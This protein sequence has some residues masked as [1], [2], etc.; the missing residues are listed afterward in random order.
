MSILAA[1]GVVSRKRRVGTIFHQMRLRADAPHVFVVGV[2]ISS[3]T[4]TGYS[5]TLNTFIRYHLRQAGCEDR[6]YVLRD[7][8][9]SSARHE[10]RKID[11]YPWLPQDLREQ[12][13]D[14]LLSVHRI[15]AGAGV[16]VCHLSDVPGGWCVLMNRSHLITAGSRLLRE[17]GCRQLAVVY[18]PW[19]SEERYDLD[20]QLTHRAVTAAGC[21]PDQVD[22][23]LAKAI[24]AAAN[25]VM[26]SLCRNRAV[27]DRPDAIVVTDDHLASRLAQAMASMDWRP[28]LV[29]QTNQ[30]LPLHYALPVIRFEFDVDEYAR[31]AVDLMLAM[32]LDLSLPPQVR[33][34]MPRLRE[35]DLPQVNAKRLARAIRQYRLDE[36][37]A[38]R[39]MVR[40]Q[41]AGCSRD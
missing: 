31:A 38:S 13:T 39:R 17:L 10:F 9:P 20:R 1:H 35:E 41:T 27:K 21:N 36:H 3:L 4:E 24:P 16:P 7:D 19:H 8:A 26:E 15:E 37:A 32:L 30:Q 11:H 34:V 29:V 2:P 6:T 18:T 28:R 14:A 25:E 23:I 33:L 5:H 40:A 22:L 12:R